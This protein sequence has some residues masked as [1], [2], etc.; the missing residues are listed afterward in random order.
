M[1]SVAPADLSLDLGAGRI[2]RMPGAI[3]LDCSREAKPDVV[4]DVDR[5]GLPFRS[6]CFASV[7][8]FDV[9]EHVDD[10]VHVV[11]EVHRVLRPGGVLFITTPHFSSANAYTDP[12]HRRALGVRSF[13]FFV[14]GHELQ[15]YSSARFRVRARRLHFHGA[16]LGRILS[17]FA[18]AWPDTYETRLAWL[19]PAW[20]LYFELEK[21][22]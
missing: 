21:L 9:L 22:A 13:D 2:Q 14:P 18:R 16:V 15:Y 3:R 20:F 6:G 19:F 8:A 11:E 4:A 7:G 12:T 5:G 10:L 1:T 17:R